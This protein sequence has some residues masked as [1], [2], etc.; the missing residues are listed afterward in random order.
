MLCDYLLILWWKLVYGGLFEYCLCEIDVFGWI[1]EVVVGQL[2]FELMLELLWS[3]IG[4]QCDVIIVLDVV[5]VVGIG[6]FDGGIS[7]CL[8]DMIWF[9]LL[10]LCDGVLLVGQ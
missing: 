5:G 2:M 9:G 4:V 3:C 8:I 7:V 6:I 1:C 10:Y